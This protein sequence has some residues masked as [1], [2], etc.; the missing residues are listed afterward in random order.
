MNDSEPVGP[1][2]RKL[3]VETALNDPAVHARLVDDPLVAERRRRYAQ[4][5][6][7]VLA[8]LTA[9]GFPGLDEVGGLQRLGVPYRAA[10]PI[11]LEWLPKTGYLPLAEDIVRT[12]S[13]AF[14]KKQ[15]LPVFLALFREPPAVSDPQRSPLAEPAAEHLRWVLG[16]GL[17]IFADPS[18]ANELI[19]LARDRRYGQART[20][21]VAHLQKTKDSRVPDVLMELLDDPTVAAFAVQALGKLKYAKARSQIAKL[22]DSPD[23]N[24]RDQARKALKRLG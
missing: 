3:A 17:G 6:S 14:A 8:D 5:A 11:L 22:A 16:N 23:R 19:A 12:L 10:V 20:E 21:I 4:S 7:G 24:V 1:L 13:V 9:A 18:V 2:P 15:A